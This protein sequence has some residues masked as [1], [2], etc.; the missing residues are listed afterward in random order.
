M[1]NT[2]TIGLKQ[3]EAVEGTKLD[4]AQIYR[5]TVR[6]QEVI[7]GGFN[8]ANNAVDHFAGYLNPLTN[9]FGAFGKAVQGRSRDALQDNNNTIVDRQ[10]T[11]TERK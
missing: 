2:G 10:L 6:D 11:T 3:I 5:L 4:I 8:V 7:K 1:K 9:L